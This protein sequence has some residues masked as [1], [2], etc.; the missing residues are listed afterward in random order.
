MELFV[1]IQDSKLRFFTENGDCLTSP[2]EL[3]L[4]ER[5]QREIAQQQAELAQQQAE[6]ERQQRELAEQEVT[7]LKAKL[8]EL[9]VDPDRLE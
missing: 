4:Q 8:R 5:Q 2:Q 3:A 7:A 6:Q 9:G 1:G